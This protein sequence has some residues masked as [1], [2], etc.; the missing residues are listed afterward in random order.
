MWTVWLGFSGAGLS[1]I[2]TAYHLQ[3]KGPQGLSYVILE[4]IR[5]DSDI[6]TFGFTW[7]PWVREAPLASGDEI[8]DYFHKS[9]EKHGIDKH[10]I[11]NHRVESA[12]W[13]SKHS[14][15][16]LHVTCDKDGERTEKVVRCRFVVMGTGYYNYEHPLEARILGLESFGGAVIHP[17]FW[18]AELAYADK[19]MVVIGSGATAVTLLPA[20]AD[21][22]KHVTML[23]RSPTYILPRPMQDRVSRILS[24]FF[25]ASIAARLNRLRFAVASYFLVTI[26]RTFPNAA[27]RSFAKIITEQLPPKVTTNPHF[28]PR[29]RPWEQRLCA[30]PDGDFYAA[31]RSGKASVTTGVIREITE[32]KIR[33]ESGEILRPDIIVTATGLKLRFGGGI[34]LSVDGA[35]IDISQKFVWRGT[36]VQDL[37]TLAFIVGYVD[38]SWTLGTDVSATTI[39][40]LLNQMKK[41]G[42]LS[43]Q[44][45]LFTISS[46]YVQTAS[47]VFP[48]GGVGQWRQNKNYLLD[49]LRASYGDLSTG[50]EMR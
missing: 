10:I 11:Y 17:Q 24:V 46:T 48:K 49:M 8:L 45:P 43:A 13:S 38:A 47:E 33:L 34:K 1:G 21:R 5:S 23:Q 41:K 4:G 25:P 26:C 12:D 44:R 36:M 39:V 27:R 42:A 14:S 16:T 28:T 6:H 35:P 3:T 31:I 19:E 9:A 20:V 37:P 29:Y 15:W 7:S 22:V 18:P 32:S 2:N 50:L 30:T 40:R